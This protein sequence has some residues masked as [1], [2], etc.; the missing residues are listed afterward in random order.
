MNN[1]SQFSETYFYFLLGSGIGFMVIAGIVCD[2]ILMNFHKS[3]ERYRK[4]KF[5]VCEVDEN[6]PNSVRVLVA[7]SFK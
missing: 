7:P 4:G 5:S 1:S 3:R 2:V 6:D